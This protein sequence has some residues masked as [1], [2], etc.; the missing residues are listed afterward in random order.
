MSKEE[1]NAFGMVYDGAI[2]K[3]EDG[4]TNMIKAI[5]KNL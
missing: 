2:E 1:I 5:H 4:K 3:N